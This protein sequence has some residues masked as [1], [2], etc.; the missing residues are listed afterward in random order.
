MKSRLRIVAGLDV[1]I[2]L[3]SL[4]T[5][6]NPGKAVKE[7]DQNQNNYYYPSDNSACGAVTVPTVVARR[8]I[9]YCSHKSILNVVI[10]FLMKA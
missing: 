9:Y 5:S 2:A 7:K 3:C 1:Y 8:V 6:S 4:I 10:V